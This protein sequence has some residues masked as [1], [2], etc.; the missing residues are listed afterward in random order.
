MSFESPKPYE[1]GEW[2][3]QSR[4]EQDLDFWQKKLLERQ[5]QIREGEKHKDDIFAQERLP[6]WR[7]RVKHYEEK[8]ARLRKLET[9]FNKLS[10]PT[11]LPSKIELASELPAYQAGRTY[12]IQDQRQPGSFPDETYVESLFFETYGSMAY[13]IL[14][15]EF[16]EAFAAYLEQRIKEISER[17]KSPVMIVEP[18]AGA[19]RLSYFLRQKLNETCAGLF[20][21]RATDTHEL[22]KDGSIVTSDRI[23]VEPLDVQVTLER[24]KPQIV[25]VSWMPKAATWDN[26]FAQDPHLQE[27]I[28]IGEPAITGG[29]VGVTDPRYDSLLPTELQFKTDEDRHD[30]HVDAMKKTTWYK[31]GFVYDRLPDVEKHQLSLGGSFLRQL[32]EGHANSQMAAFRRKA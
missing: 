13:E 12:T 30:P 1:S 28:L 9:F 17:T 8:I 32:K 15:Q 5:E 2:S 24:Y 11:Y 6:V 27:Y 10:D 18:G 7:E 4:I 16:V 22:A 26:L 31:H 20:E 29:W 23:P 25:L 3:K 14:T 21:I 19:G